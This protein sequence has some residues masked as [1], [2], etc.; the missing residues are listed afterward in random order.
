[1]QRKSKLLVFHSKRKSMNLDSF[2]I[3]L[4]GVK[5]TPERN[6]KYLGILIDNYLSWEDH[7]HNLSIKLRRANG[8]LAKLRHFI[9][10]RT[11]ISV[12]HAIFQS[13]LQYGCIVWSQSMAKNILLFKDTE[14]LKVDDII[15]NNQIILPFQFVNNDLNNL[16]NSNINKYHTR[17]MEERGLTVPKINSVS[18]GERS[19]RFQIPK[20]WN[21]LINTTT[22][23]INSTV[24]LK[25]ALKMSTLA[26]Y[27][28][29]SP[30]IELFCIYC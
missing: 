30:S 21:L 15:K 27:M 12:Y 25:H 17:N 3:K 19:L 8:I 28:F 24:Q 11:R 5:L 1:M 10:K 14:I 2:P 20:Q 9:P 22:K 23:Q 26:T 16:F 29:A 18:Y 13:H 4:D 7:I 6:V